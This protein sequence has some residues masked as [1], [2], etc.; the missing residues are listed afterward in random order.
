MIK[1]ETGAMEQTFKISEFDITS[2]EDLKQIVDAEFLQ[3]AE[4]RFHDMAQ[5]LIRSQQ[6]NEEF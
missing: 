2:E 1:L 3:E 4:A 5:S 6:R